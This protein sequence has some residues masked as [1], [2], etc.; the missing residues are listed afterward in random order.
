MSGM[1]STRDTAESGPILD[2]VPFA[3]LRVT[4][5]VARN[6][7]VTLSN[8]KGTMSNMGPHP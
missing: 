2:M 1:S 8:A 4:V 3:A 7:I 5:I 6:Q